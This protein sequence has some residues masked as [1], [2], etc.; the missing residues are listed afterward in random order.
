MVPSEAGSQY[1]A[2]PAVAVDRDLDPGSGVVEPS[3]ATG[4]DVLELRCDLA[5]IM[6]EPP[7]TSQPIEPEAPQE[8]GGAI[9]YYALGVLLERV[10]L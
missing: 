6:Q 2:D 4:E 9:P 7:S 1:L 5:D 3:T 8:A 10:P